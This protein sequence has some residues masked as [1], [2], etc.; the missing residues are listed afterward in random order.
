MWHEYRSRY[1]TPAVFHLARPSRDLEKHKTLP[2]VS[3]S[4]NVLENLMIV[5]N[6]LIR[7]TGKEWIDV[8]FKGISTF[9]VLSFIC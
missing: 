6:M 3:F 2:V 4:L 7:L 1:E 5:I 8:I 9:R